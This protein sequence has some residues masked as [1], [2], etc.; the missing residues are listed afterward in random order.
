[1]F[2]FRSWFADLPGRARGV[3]AETTYA[4]RLLLAAHWAW[5][6]AHRSRVLVT[7]VP[8][9]L[10]GFCAGKA[11][12]AEP[13]ALTV[14]VANGNVPTLTW[15]APWATSCAGSGGWGGAKA[16]TGSQTLP[17]ITVSTTYALD[18]VSSANTTAFLSWLAVTQNTDGTPLT[19]LAGYR[20]FE[21]PSVGSLALRATTNASTLAYQAQNLPV[22]TTRYFGIAALTTQGAQSPMSNLMSLTTT[23]SQQASSSV[24]VNIPRAPTLTVQA[25]TAYDVRLRWFKYVL[26]KPVGQLPVGSPCYEDFE[27]AGGY[28]RVDRSAVTFTR[29]TNDPVIVAVCA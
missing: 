2:D 20:V 10:L 14:S 1:M 12:A 28:F 29:K 26:N 21:G 13:P 25:P 9:L 17:A 3:F 15:S 18:C 27:L 22:G 6:K 16:P 23:P 11:D 7:L 24:T 4:L 5:L 19:N 8:L